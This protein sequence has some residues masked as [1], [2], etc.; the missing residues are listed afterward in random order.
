MNLLFGA[1]R[2]C[3]EEAAPFHSRPLERAMPRTAFSAREHGFPF[4][5]F[6]TRTSV[7]LPGGRRIEL[8]GRWG[9]MAWAALDAFYAGE[10][11]PG[12]D[13]AGAPAGGLAAHLARRLEQCFAAPGAARFGIWAMADDERV[14]RVTW[15]CEIPG[16]CASIDDGRPVVLG[17]L[18]ARGLEELG[19][20]IRLVVATGYDGDPVRGPLRLLVYDDETPGE[21]VVLTAGAGTLGIAASNQA[22]PWRGLF[23]YDYTPQPLSGPEPAA[24]SRTG[25]HCGELVEFPRLHRAVA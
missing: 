4:R 15:D 24:A 7:T 17:L 10:P 9:G 19:G 6:L 1:F 14:A 11:L 3:R 21:E 20:G 18:R 12:L 16:I 8:V 2:F 23:A 5:N 13:A 25:N 22:R